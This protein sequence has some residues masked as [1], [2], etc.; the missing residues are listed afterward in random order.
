LYSFFFLYTQ[1]CIDDNLRKDGAMAAFPCQ[2]PWLSKAVSAALICC[3]AG[4]VFCAPSLS[5]SASTPEAVELSTLE[6]QELVEQ[7][8]AQFEQGDR[9]KAQQ[10][11]E[12]ASRVF[13]ENYAVPYYLGVIY[14]EQG[15]R[16]EAIA[17]WQRYV[18]MDPQSENAFKIRKMLTLLLREEARESARQAVAAEATIT[19]GQADDQT[20]AVTTFK[21]LGSNQ[22]GPLGKGMAAMLIS[23]LSQV[24]DLQVVDRIRLQAL[25]EEMALGTSGLVDKQTAPQVGRLLKAK[26][27]TTGS[28]T[29]LES[30]NM[31]IAS[32]VMDTDQQTSIGSQQA[33][34][35][36][37]QFYD[38]EKKI[39]CQ[40]IED[41]GRD[42]RT[43]PAGFK[44]IHTR[45]M[46]ALVAYSR[47]LDDF[48]QER[49]VEARAMFQKSLEED[50]QFELAE[51]ALMA[52]PTVAILS[53]NT[54]ELVTGA[55]SSGL[56]APAAGT[57]VIGTTT[58]TGI[59]VAV[60][61]AGATVGVAP[62]TALIAGVA[63]LGGGAAL[64]GAGGGGGGG[65]GSDS[66]QP[67][68]TELDGG[69][70][71]TWTD[72]TGGASGNVT[73]DLNQSG[74][75]VSGTVSAPNEF[76]MT[77]GNVSGTRSGNNFDLT[78]QS[79]TE[80]IEVSGTI[81]EIA[82]TMSGTYYYSASQQGCLGDTGRFSM[83][84]T[85]GAGITW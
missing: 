72:D 56:P 65:G 57:A 61:V 81:D 13:P 36:L 10:G 31:M 55:A 44:K 76:C 26:H 22:L 66:I 12:N 80:T 62:T 33:Q 51:D 54:S 29:D 19:S 25:L 24:P 18:E 6:K 70:T 5:I 47:G 32:V 58:T 34:G 77:N 15:R 85:G 73:L 30:I 23:D 69:W 84:L 7:S 52:T 3:T 9:A 8:V 60:P 35:G 16:A 53:M 48:D 11:L 41:I 17:Q 59:A 71:G 39:A 14:L 64:A 21:N 79:G 27:V 20:I 75:A 63:V 40:I 2:S 68:A 83:S 67:A 46:P 37:A 74:S 42:C 49:Y 1:F 38:L 78:V 43:V 28:L 45:S 4:L 82:M 50:P